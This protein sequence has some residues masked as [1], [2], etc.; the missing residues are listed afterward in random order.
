[1]SHLCVGLIHMKFYSF[2]SNIIPT[3]WVC[4]SGSGVASAATLGCL[5]AVFLQIHPGAGSSDLHQGLPPTFLP[6]K[7]V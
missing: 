3:P 7:E 1:M 2:D 4:C 6:A 5:G